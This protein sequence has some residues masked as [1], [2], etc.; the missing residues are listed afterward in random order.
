MTTISGNTYPVR[1]QIKALGGRWNPTSKTWSVPDDKAEQARRLVA[2]APSKSANRTRSSR[3]SGIC[4]HC[5]DRC[6]PRYATCYECS[7]GGQSFYAPNGEFVLG[8]DD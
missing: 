4:E 5:G 8:S 6:N 1:D 2:S 7:H 3:G